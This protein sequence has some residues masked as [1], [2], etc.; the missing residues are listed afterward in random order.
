[1]EKCREC[2]KDMSSRA[3]VCPHCGAER[4]RKLR[5]FLLGTFLALVAASIWMSVLAPSRPVGPASGPAGQPAAGPAS[6]EVLPAPSWEY[7]REPDKM[8]GGESVG[9]VVRSVSSLNLGFP[10]HGRNYGHL[11]VRQSPQYG[12][13]VLLFVDKGQFICPVDGCSIMVRFDDKPAM[14]MSVVEPADHD[15]K[16]LFLSSPKRFIEAARKARIIRVQATMYQEGDQQ[17]EFAPP[18]PLQWPPAKKAPA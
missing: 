4:P 2:G 9:A 1:M 17:M 15:S 5:R 16:V 10:Y 12:L 18:E 14:R 11:Q 6:E 7:S 3:K 13:D 8:R